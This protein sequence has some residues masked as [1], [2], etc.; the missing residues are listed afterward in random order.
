MEGILK[1][2][3]QSPRNTNVLH[4]VYGRYVV[5]YAL[6]M[7]CVQDILSEKEVICFVL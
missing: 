3:T 1:L 6:H 2:D 4:I 5:L 7:H